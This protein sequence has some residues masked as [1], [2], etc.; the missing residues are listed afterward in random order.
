MYLSD[1]VFLLLLLLFKFFL[2]QE[3]ELRSTDKQAKRKEKPNTIQVL[4]TRNKMQTTGNRIAAKSMQC[5]PR[6]G[7]KIS[8]VDFL[9]QISHRC[10]LMQLH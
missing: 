7:G 8:A 9:E 4:Q 5:L 3:L 6:G 10:K 2:F 1:D